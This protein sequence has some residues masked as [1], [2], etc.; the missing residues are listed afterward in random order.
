MLAAVTSFP[1]AVSAIYLAT[2]GRGGA[3]L[4]I[5]LNSN[6]LNVLAGLLLPAAIVGLG[7]RSGQTT[8]I[9]TW[10]AAFTIVVL[11]LALAGS[12]LR[13]TTG[14]AIILGYAAF[15]VTVALTA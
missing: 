4:S 5:A 10:Y 14:V 6:A 11:T 12:G 9:A 8:L 13:R 7:A 1:N 2:R 15:V 3:T